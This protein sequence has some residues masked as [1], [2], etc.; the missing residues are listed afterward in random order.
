MSYTVFSKEVTKW[1]KDNDLPWC[2]TA[3]DSAEVTQARLDAWKAGS[4]HMLAQW[5]AEERYKELIS[6]AHSGWYKDSE[7][8]EPLAEHFASNKLFEHLYF[9]CERGI[10]FETEDMLSLI[11][12]AQ[13]ETKD[14]DFL[15]IIEFDLESYASSKEY[16]CLG[17]IAKYRKRALDKITR[18]LSYLSRADAPKEY[19][20]NVQ[21]L[22]DSIISL[23]VKKADLKAF[24]HKL[25]EEK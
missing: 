9:L 3:Y 15:R 22:R 6:C 17:E 24:K 19:I 7:F 23:T 10:R 16:D 25:S 18:Y 21:N 12:S 5:I 11:K 4:E 1:L 2:G 20:S 13:E 14:I 8:F